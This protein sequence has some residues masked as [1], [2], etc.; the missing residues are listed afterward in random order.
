MESSSSQFWPTG[1]MFDKPD[2][3]EKNKQTVQ[4][5]VLTVSSA[6]VIIFGLLFQ[7][8]L[9]KVYDHA[10]Y[11]QPFKKLAAHK[12]VQTGFALEKQRLPQ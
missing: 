3:A 9:H 8:D 10:G 6:T 2:L 11:S 12:S 1:V 7:T 5:K 4:V